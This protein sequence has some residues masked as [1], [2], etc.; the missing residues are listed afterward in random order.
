MNEENSRDLAFEIANILSEK[1]GKDVLVIDVKAKTVIADYFVIASA[2]STTAVNALGDNVED[3]LAKEGRE[4]LRRDGFAGST[5][6]V[7]DYGGVIVHVFHDEAREYY[8]LER[9]WI[10]GNNCERVE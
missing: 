9:L 4:P 3:K 8:H 6:I 1:K 10:D 2:K 7:I 5:W